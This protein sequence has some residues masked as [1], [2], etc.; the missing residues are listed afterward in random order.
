MKDFER[1]LR[2]LVKETVEE[3]RLDAEDNILTKKDAKKLIRK[4]ALKNYFN[5]TEAAEYLGVSISTFWRM[6]Q[7]YQIKSVVIDNIRLWRKSDLE[8]FITKNG[9]EGYL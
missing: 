6:R 9:V 2:A 3:D 7:K 8:D 4:Y 5:A 1:S